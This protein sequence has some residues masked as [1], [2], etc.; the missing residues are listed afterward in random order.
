MSKYS[1]VAWERAMAKKITWCK[2]VEIVGFSDRGMRR[3]RKRYEEH[4]YD[5]LLDKCWEQPF[6]QAGGSDSS[7]RRGI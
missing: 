5:G 2:A 7:W 6:P 4:G 1:G 3:W